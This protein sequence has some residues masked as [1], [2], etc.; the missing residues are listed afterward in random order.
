MNSIIN[1][2]VKSNLKE[3]K[4][5][6]LMVIVA[7]VL[8]T[9]L[10]TSVGIISIT[11]MKNQKEN[12]IRNSGSA[13]AYYRRLNEEQVE[14]LKAHKDIEVV[15]ENSSQLGK[16][17]LDESLFSFGYIDENAMKLSNMGVIKGKAPTKSNE[18]ALEYKALEKLGYSDK[19]GQ[20][21]KIKYHD[22]NKNYTEKEFIISGILPANENSEII[23]S[24]SIIASKDFMIENNYD[25]PFRANI[26]IKDEDKL[27]REELEFKIHEVAK[28]LGFKEANTMLN[29]MYLIWMKP[30][31]DVVLGA[32]LI[33]T[34]VM[35]SAILVIY[36]IFYISII[37][38]I[39]DFG[40]LKAIGTTKAQIKAIIRK[41]GMILS[42]IAIPIGLALGCIISNILVGNLLDLGYENN[43]KLSLKVNILIMITS[44]MLTLLTVYISLVKPSKIAAKI[45]PVE[46]MKYIESS[47]SKK[48]KRKGYLAID[49]LKL[50]KANL[51]RNKKRTIITVLSLSLSGIIIIA[52]STMMMSMNAEIIVK[53]SLAG[54]FSF[55]HKYTGYDF[56]KEGEAFLNNNPLNENF[57]NEIKNIDGVKSIDEVREVDATIPN[58]GDMLKEEPELKVVEVDLAGYND[59][60]LKIAGDNLES[61]KFNLEKI[62]SGEEILISGYVER[63][64][65]FKPG[66]TV[67]V[68]SYEG[69]KKVEKEV[70]VQ[71]KTNSDFGGS[72]ITSIDFVKDPRYNTSININIDKNK[73]KE[74]GKVLSTLSEENKN[75]GYTS[76][77]KSLKE[78]EDMFFAM[79]SMGY[80]L[81]IIIGVISLVN[82][83]NTMIS[84]IMARKKELGILQAIG[85]SDKQLLK[86][87]KLE[88]LFYTSVTLTS[89][90]ILG[91]IIGYIAYKAMY[92]SGA[93][94]M[95]YKF[96]FIQGIII[97]LVMIAVQFIISSIID[98]IFNKE[99]LIDRIRYSE[100]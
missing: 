35:F 90:L 7:I 25:T 1:N 20:K 18:I 60:M 55:S 36:N 72:L 22:I 34:L 86:M 77:T 53:Q 2:I 12:S 65:G 10:L 89:S 45:S 81:I 100:N 46:A 99:S 94:Y 64:H 79:N 23:D 61:G 6:S 88:G 8:T 27:S 70:K 15:G 83:I 80:A 66:D 9:I 48:K 43:Y 39:Q 63:W 82:L 49:L 59:N 30:D 68:I 41:E 11:M 51:S 5:R 21:V 95:A 16:F 47:D 50:T 74:V 32:V 37:N 31:P 54:E 93:T 78:N 69:G 87:L 75:L 28:E 29:D 85:M 26:R 4:L 97:T 58:S 56:E 52:G 24:Y 84:S 19:I 73:E 67:K 33:C 62:K 40:K 96:P 17:E 14:K 92:N 91:S 3:N 98:K 44:A 76:F 38:K 71:G 13:H 42:V 57:I